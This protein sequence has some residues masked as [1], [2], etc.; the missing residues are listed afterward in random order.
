MLL[1]S[2]ANI[3]MDFEAAE[4]TVQLFELPHEIVVPDTLYREELDARHPHLR[5]LGLQ[6]RT[7]TGEKS[8]RRTHSA[9]DS[10]GSA[11]TTCSRSY[12]PEACV[13]PW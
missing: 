2:D 13:A 12:S 4:L 10:R 11:S 3:F 6:V 1:V 8:A 5:A 7:L 9:C